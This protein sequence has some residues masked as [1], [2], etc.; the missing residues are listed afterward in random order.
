MSVSMLTTCF[1]FIVNGKCLRWLFHYT[2]NFRITNITRTYFLCVVVVARCG[3]T[4]RCRFPFIYL[5]AGMCVLSA[6]FCSL[7]RVLPVL[8]LFCKYIRVSRKKNTTTKIHFSVSSAIG[9]HVVRFGW[10]VV[11]S[12]GLP[13][14][15]LH[16]TVC[17]YACL[18]VGWF[19]FFSLH[20]F[21][22]FNSFTVGC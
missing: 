11:R 4:S 9:L 16:V 1:M 14:N 3:C 18:F 6:I 13:A 20:I 8:F 12:F 17:A 10:T 19:S 7:Y 2:Q 5:S 21:I 15:R 22:E